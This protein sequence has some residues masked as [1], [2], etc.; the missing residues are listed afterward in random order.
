MTQ[1]EMFKTLQSATPDQCHSLVQKYLTP[2]VY[3]KLK[4]KKTAL[5]GTLAHCINTGE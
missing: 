4:D 1:D 3:N 2:E 5:G